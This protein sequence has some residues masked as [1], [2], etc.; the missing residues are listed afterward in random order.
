MMGK[1]L[2]LLLLLGVQS[3]QANV[4]IQG[5]SN[6]DHKT[7]HQPNSY[8]AYGA[9]HLNLTQKY[10]GI[11]VIYND[12]V[13]NWEEYIQYFDEILAEEKCKFSL[14]NFNMNYIIYSGAGVFGILIVAYLTYLLRK[15]FKKVR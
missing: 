12:Y 14:N 5:G 15:K 8:F 11:P 9:E 7:S 2:L 4:E 3:L 10:Y 6:I 13:E 1:I